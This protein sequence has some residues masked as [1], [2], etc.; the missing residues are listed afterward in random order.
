MTDSPTQYK[1]S[2]PLRLSK[3]VVRI[4]QKESHKRIMLKSVSNKRPTFHNSRIEGHISFVDGA[5]IC[6]RT[7]ATSG[8]IVISPDD[9]MSMEPWWIDDTDKGKPKNSVKNLSHC[10]FIHHKSHNE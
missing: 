4:S 2:I 6:L 3:I 7:A 8:P 5:R 10:H 1:D 9:D